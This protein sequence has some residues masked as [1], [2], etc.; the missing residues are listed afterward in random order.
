M[1]ANGE[2]ARALGARC[3]LCPLGNHKEERRNS[4]LVSPTPAKKRLKL[5][6][7]GD[8]PQRGDEGARKPFQGKSGQLLMRELAKN[9]V[10]EGE[11]HFTLSAL[12]RGESKEDNEKARECCAPRLL[13][14]LRELPIRGG[15]DSGN[16]GVG[17]DVPMLLF[18]AGSAKS[19]LG[20]RSLPSSRGF[21]WRCRGI[22]GSQ[23][24]GYLREAKKPTLSQGKRDGNTLKAAGL[25]GRSH[26]SG[27]LALATYS[28]SFILKAD[29]WFPIW[30]LDIKRACLLALG[31]IPF[32]LE[33]EAIHLSGGVEVLEALDDS[34]VVSCDKI[35]RAHV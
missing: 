29:T 26:L 3:D 2:M 20:L 15:G 31:K 7:V 16:V 24:K 22:E 19:V 25:E 1:R 30:Q 12:C 21:I 10:E 6:V 14:E 18:E 28:P 9:G 35:G 11:C 8:S 17:S 13:G 4:I 32:P 27:R 23:I 34:K 5:I 33:D